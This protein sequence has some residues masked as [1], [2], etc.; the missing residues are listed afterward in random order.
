[1]SL[2]RVAVIGAGAWGTALA[3]LL[4]ERGHEAVLWAY[5]AD[6]CA[7]MAR[8]RENDL[9]L[10]GARL[11]AGLRFTADL[12]EAASAGQDLL[13]SVMPSH[14]VRAVWRR[15][16]PS[17]HPEALVASATKGIEEGTLLLPTQVIAECLQGAGAAPRPLVAFSGPSFA[18]EAAERKPTAVAAASEE[19]GAAAAV[20]AAFAGSCVRVYTGPDPIGTQLGG[21]LKNVVALAAGIADGLSLGHNARAALIVRGLA[22]MS[23]LG[24]AMGGRPG[25]FAGLAGLGDLVLTCT[26]DLSRNRTVGMRLGKGEK[27]PDILAS[28]A[29]VAEGVHTAPAAVG[30]ARRHGAELPICEQVHAVLFEG[31]D[32][33]EAVKE[34]M[35][36]PLK[37]ERV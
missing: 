33:R 2:L 3:G 35:A 13:L 21:A 10:P 24:G 31:K 25:T 1:M 18:R 15:L 4:A 23:R 34:L 9:Y 26:G 7:R 32:P 17:L 6:L 8:S 37:A 27:L 12:A 29:A 22:E 5:E 11:H 28:M 30:L 19:E 20:Q 14:V 36:R 16:A